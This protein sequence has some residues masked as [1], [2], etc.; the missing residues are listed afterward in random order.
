MSSR[1]VVQEFHQSKSFSQEDRGL[2]L[3]VDRTL[4]M[5]PIL[6][7][8]SPS[9]HKEFFNMEVLE[10]KSKRVTVEQDQQCS[11]GQREGESGENSWTMDSSS[12][13]NR[14][15]ELNCY[16]QKTFIEIFILIIF[17]TRHREIMKPWQYVSLLF[18]IVTMCFM[19]VFFLM[20]FWKLFEV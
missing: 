9:C 4:S 1:L 6:I 19:I 7:V 10:E 12:I 5:P 8:T 20:S 2:R 15:A 18:C 13:G 16:Q 3:K 14:Q 17:R 11:H